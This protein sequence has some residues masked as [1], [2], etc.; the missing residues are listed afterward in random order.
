MVTVL[1]TESIAVTKEPPGM[2][3]T[4][5]TEA[6]TRMPAVD[7]TVMTAL[8]LV[9]VARSDTVSRTRKPVPRPLTE[10][11]ARM[12]P[13]T[14]MLVLPLPVMTPRLPCCASLM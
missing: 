5:L 11:S 10:A 13:R 4:A 7:G 14:F 8:L 12:S 6:P 9:I 1:L 2:P 3:A